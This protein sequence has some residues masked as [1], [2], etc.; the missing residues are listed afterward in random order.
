M[1]DINTN[2]LNKI[3]W[4]FYNITGVTIGAYDVNFQPLSSKRYPHCSLCKAVRK[5]DELAK[6]C[7]ECDINGIKKCTASRSTQPYLCHM[8]LVE[9]ITPIY[10]DNIL[11]GYI[12]IGQMIDKSNMER[13]KKN[14][15]ALGDNIDKE[16]LLKAVGDVSVFSKDK[17]ESVVSM[18]E[19]CTKYL[20]HENV[21]NVRLSL[22]SSRIN[23]YILNNLDKDIGIKL[24]CDE[25]HISRSKLYEVSTEFFK[26]GVTDYIR[27]LRIEQAKKL[28]KNGECTVSETAKLVGMPDANYFTKVFKKYVGIT[29]LQFK[30]GVKK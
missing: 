12:L 3:I 18:M 13:I 24:I 10:S 2:K 19:I 4:D 30:N 7:H 14:I 8:G 22:L 9:A 28:L 1:L 6:K 25:L 11:A 27:F 26:M 23:D 21:V 16:E 17:I 29:P 15:Q 5:Y 20:M